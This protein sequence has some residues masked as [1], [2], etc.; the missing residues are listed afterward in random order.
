MVAGE[1][2]LFPVKERDSTR[3]VSYQNR[4]CIF[5][6]DDIELAT[7]IIFKTKIAEK[8]EELKN[9]Y[10]NGRMTTKRNLANELTHYPV[11]GVASVANTLRNQKLDEKRY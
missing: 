7:D 10:G 4:G 3:Y 5:P 6:W 9:T 1:L 11:N 2:C 8:R